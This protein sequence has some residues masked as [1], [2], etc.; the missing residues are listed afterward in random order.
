MSKLGS[1]IREHISHEVLVST[2]IANRRFLIS[3]RCIV[4]VTK[5][6]YIIDNYVLLSILS[7]QTTT[8]IIGKH[9]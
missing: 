3:S 4:Q 2:L 5:V 8:L 9:G 1:M 7:V 6:Y